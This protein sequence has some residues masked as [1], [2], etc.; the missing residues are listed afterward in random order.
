MAMTLVRTCRGCGC[1]D[2][3]ACLTMAGPCWWVDDDL[4][5]RCA[6]IDGADVSIYSEA[7][8]DAFIREGRCAGGSL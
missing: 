8:A 1:T 2:H 5:S 6:G 7:E 3:A 4:C